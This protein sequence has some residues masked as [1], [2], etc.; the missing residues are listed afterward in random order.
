VNTREPDGEIELTCR[1]GDWHTTHP[2]LARP[3]VD[4]ELADL[5]HVGLPRGGAAQE[6]MNTCDELGIQLALRDVVGTALEGAD[7][8]DRIGT[9]GCEH[10]DRDVPVPAP[11]W[12]AFAEAGTQL[13]LTREDDVRP[14]ALGDIESLRTPPCLDDVEPIRAQVALEISRPGGIGIGKEKGCTH[15]SNGR[16]MDEPPPDVLYARSVTITPQLSRTG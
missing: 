6:C 16:A 3:P 15:S 1:E 13:R 10:D 5:E 7:A 4:D 2:H 8:L 14:R 9:R 11:T 12:L